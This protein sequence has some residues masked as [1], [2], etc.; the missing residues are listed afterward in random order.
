LAA[1]RDALLAAGADMAID[2]VAD[3]IPALEGATAR[4]RPAV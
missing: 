2:S 4:M 3:L 1:A